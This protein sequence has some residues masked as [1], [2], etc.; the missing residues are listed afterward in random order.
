M[1]PRPVTPCRCE[2][3]GFCS[4]HRCEK[5]YSL[6]LLCRL[7]QCQFDLW[8]N[9]E[10]P[11]L[12]RARQGRAAAS[13]IGAFVELPPCRHRGHEPLEHVECELCGGRTEHLPVYACAQLGK[14]TA[15]RYGTRTEVMRT[16]PACIRC[17]KYEAAES[18]ALETVEM[19]MISPRSGHRLE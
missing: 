18:A 13:M 2:T 5:T 10:G 17:D 11:C 14:C 1:Y 19:Q 4:R 3:A 6:V 15:R 9:G 8:E 16:M 12:D 7:N